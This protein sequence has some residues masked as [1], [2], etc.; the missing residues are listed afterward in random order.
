M[1]PCAASSSGRRH[2]EIETDL[3][4][5]HVSQ[6]GAISREEEMQLRAYKLPSVI[7]DITET[8]AT[9]LR[10]ILSS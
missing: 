9:S 5:L 6:T 8:R 7:G 1:L 10:G 4:I 3:R 2:L